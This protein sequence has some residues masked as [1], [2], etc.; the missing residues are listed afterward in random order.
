M[1]LS[2]DEVGR[3]GKAKDFIPEA[4]ESSFPFKKN[5]KHLKLKLQQQ[6]DAMHSEFS[7]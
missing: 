2:I 6:C 7:K 4:K 1:C 5:P 3:W